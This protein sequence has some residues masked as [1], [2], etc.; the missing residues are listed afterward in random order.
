[1][2]LHRDGTSSAAYKI[3]LSVQPKPTGGGGGGLNVFYWHKIFAL[4]S[5][6]VEKQNCLA[7]PDSTSCIRICGIH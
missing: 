6:V 2:R 4:D 1:M 5:V 3:I 7:N